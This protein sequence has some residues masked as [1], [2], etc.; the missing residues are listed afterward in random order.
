MFSRIIRKLNYL[1]LRRLNRMQQPADGHTAERIPASIDQVTAKLKAMFSDCHDFII[2]ELHMGDKHDIRMAIAFIDGMISNERFDRNILRPLMIEAK[3]IGVDTDMN[4]RNIIDILKHDLLLSCQVREVEDF[5]QTVDIILGGDVV[6]YIDGVKTALSASVKGWEVRSVEEPN[7]DIV[8]RGP[9]EGFT[10]TLRTNTSMIRRKIK[11]PKLKFEHLVIGKRT[12][13]EVC[14]CYIKGIANDSIV[15]TVKRRLNGIQ[16]DAIL[17]SGYIEEFIEDAPLSLF[18]TTGS[19][20][21]PD[22]VAGRILEGRVAIICDGTPFVLTVPML[23]IENIQT[24]EDYYRR[25]VYSSLVRV[26]RL[27]ALV[28]STSL[29]GLYVALINFHQAVI[30]LKLMLNTAA[31]REG[32]PF[33][34]FFEALV[35]GGGIRD[36]EGGR[37]QDA[38][39]GRAG[40]QHSRSAGAGRISRTGWA[41]QQPDGDSCRADRNKQFCQPKAR[42]CDAVYQVF[43]AGGG[44]HTGD[45]GDYVG[46]NGA[47]HTPVQPKKLWCALSCAHSPAQRDGP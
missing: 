21:K 2:R 13:T 36:S 38:P 18:R 34:P 14:I 23:F 10:E 1:K 44:Q 16:T 43:C 40:R 45:Y 37:A 22:I 20:E 12:K 6:I 7:T 29:P 8:I 35:M 19:T 5:V 47:V 9:R 17:E 15:D 3:K 25:A 42:G 4:S 27:I 31:S 26:L 33:S 24:S 11:S 32:I 28:I 30:P 46:Y 39:P 41:Y